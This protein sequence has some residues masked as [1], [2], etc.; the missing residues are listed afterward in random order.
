LFEWIKNKKAANVVAVILEKDALL[1]KIAHIN[2]ETLHMFLNQEDK[3]EEEEVPKEEL[4][5]LIDNQENKIISNTK[6]KN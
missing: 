4:E 2:L 6:V 5:D 1:V 3:E